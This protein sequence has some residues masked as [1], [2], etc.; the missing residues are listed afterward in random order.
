MARSRR[1][2]AYYVTYGARPD[3]GKKATSGEIRARSRVACRAGVEDDAH[4]EGRTR[5]SA[6]TRDRDH[7]WKYFGDGRTVAPRNH[8]MHD[9]LC[10]K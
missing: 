7:G 4:I 8:P 10:R 6:G 2:P 5:G 3:Q 1:A 9:R